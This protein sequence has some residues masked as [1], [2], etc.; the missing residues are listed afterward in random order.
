M[1]RPSLP[2]ALSIA[3]IVGGSL[4][5]AAAADNESGQKP[6]QD[7]KPAAQKDCVTDTGGGF[8]MSGKQATYV[9]AL[10]NKCE[11][12]LRCKVYALVQNARGDV[13]G[14]KTLTLAPKSKGTAAKQAYVLKVKMMGGMAQVSRECKEF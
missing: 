1:I 2:L 3:L 7:A 6:P 4:N 9:I 10:E 14:H 13:R 11:M 8:K 5:L 12:R